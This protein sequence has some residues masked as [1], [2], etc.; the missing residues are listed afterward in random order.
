MKKKRKK[1]HSR[2]VAKIAEQ[3]K[4]TLILTGVN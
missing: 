2:E 3:G 1:M 4:D